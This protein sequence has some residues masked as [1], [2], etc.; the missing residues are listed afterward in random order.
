MEKKLL[1]R[2]ALYGAAECASAADALKLLGRQGIY[3]YSALTSADSYNQALAGRLAQTY[4]DLYRI[5]PD[6]DVIRV[7]SDRFG[8]HNLKLGLK[9]KRGGQAGEA[10][11]IDI[12]SPG[13]P[14]PRSIRADAAAGKFTRLPAHLAEAARQAEAAYKRSPAPQTLDIR[15]DCAMF[16]RLL[17]LCDKLN[18]E[19]ITGYVRASIDLLNLKTLM[20]MKKR[21]TPA[22]HL[23]E[24]LAAGGALEESFFAGAYEKP[25]DALK[26]LFH[27]KFFGPMFETA[28]SKFDRDGSLYWLE[29]AADN[30]LLEYLKEA[31]FIAFGP[32]PFFA[33]ALGVENEIRQIRVIMA[34][35]L[36]GMPDGMLRERLGGIYP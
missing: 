34:F 10:A 15:V 1:T 14:P 7:L 17:A 32:E 36:N 31:K 28:A 24:A 11:L 21:Q 12:R 8:Y 26:T 2:D 5:V 25:L 29:K 19:F 4:A 27:Y 16:K 20:R 30:Y 22:Y 33:F 6:P 9:A 3:S 35:K 13:E 18:N 23:K